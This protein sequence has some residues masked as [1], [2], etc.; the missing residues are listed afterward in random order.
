MA[1]RSEL[2][3]LGIVMALA[4]LPHYVLPLHHVRANAK[5]PSTSL[6]VTPVALHLNKVREPHQVSRYREPE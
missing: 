3:S 2:I 1:F 6:V 4:S 5:R